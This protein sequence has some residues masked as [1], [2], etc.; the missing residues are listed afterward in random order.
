Q[1]EH[2]GKDCVT[3]MLNPL[4]PPCALIVRPSLHPLLTLILTLTLTLGDCHPH[5]HPHPWW[6]HLPDPPLPRRRNQEEQPRGAARSGSQEQQLG[7][8]ARSGSQE[9]WARQVVGQGQ[10]AHAPHSQEAQPG[11]RSSSQQ[12]GSKDSAMAHGDNSVTVT[13]PPLAHP[14]PPLSHPTPPHPTPPQQ[15]LLALSSLGVSMALVDCKQG[16]RAATN[17]EPASTVPSPYP[18]PRTL[19]RR[20]DT[21]H[22]WKWPPGAGSLE[23]AARSGQPGAGSLERAA[24]SG[25]PGAGSLERAAYSGQPEAG[26]LERA[27]WSGQPGAKPSLAYPSLA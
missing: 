25:Q 1:E 2:G 15:T 21:E 23:R 26:S 19:P 3:A 18:V 24:W 6:H 5:P 20:R 13:R 27:T 4:A 7:A 14:T 16:G 8:A 12:G 22:S 9:A 10:E 11:G 17:K